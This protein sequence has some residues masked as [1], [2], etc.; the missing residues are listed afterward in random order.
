MLVT[1]LTFVSVSQACEIS[2]VSPREDS[3][4]ATMPATGSSATRITRMV[5]I[6]R[7]RGSDSTFRSATRAAAIPTIVKSKTLTTSTIPY[8]WPADVR[9]SSAWLFPVSPGLDSAQ[10][11]ISAAPIAPIPSSAA[12]LNR[13]GTNTSQQPIATTAAIAA[14]R[15]NDRATTLIKIAT[16]GTARP[17][18]TGELSRRLQ[19]HRHGGRPIAAITPIAF[20]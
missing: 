18:S 11:V 16:P 2:P 6:R 9:R 8:V 10:P 7:R 13:R 17:R 20:Q 14:E 1:A 15:E 4:T 19:I 5:P 12:V 3:A